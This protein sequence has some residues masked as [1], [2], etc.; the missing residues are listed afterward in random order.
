MAITDIDQRN[1]MLAAI[2]EFSEDAIISK[3]LNGY[4]TSWNKSA[5]RMFGYTAEEAIG[6]NIELI[7]PED[8]KSEEK[9]IISNLREG[10][11]IEHF[12]TIRLT[13]SGQLI[14][15]SLTVSPIKNSLGVVTGA[16]KIARDIT[17]QVLAEEL[18]S[19]H[20]TRL[21]LINAFGRKIV[22]HLDVQT[23]LQTVT[24][25]CTQLSGAVFGA[26]FYNKIDQKG[27]TYTLYTLSGA[28]KE[29]FDKFGMPRN[30][31]V[32][33]ATFLG[34]SPVRSDDITKDPR[35]GKNYPHNGMPKGHLPVVSYLAVPVVS[36]TGAVI[37]GLFFGHPKACVFK[38]EHELLVTA[39]ASQASI[40]L[41]N[42]KLYEDVNSL[43]RKKDE[44]IGFI[45]HELK[46][47][48]TTL[49][50]YLEISR[51]NLEVL[52]QVQPKLNKQVRRLEEIISDL[53]DISKIEA[54][55][56]DFSFSRIGLCALVKKSLDALN[57]ADHE[58]EFETPATEI[59]VNVD[60]QKMTQVFVNLLSNAIKYSSPGTKI[61]LTAG[62]FGSEARFT[63][64]DQG[65]GILPEDIERIFSQF[66]RVNESKDNVQGIGLGLYI[67]R[68]IV[69]GH[70]G[71]IWAE[72]EHGKG[73]TFYVSFPVERS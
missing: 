10:R 60:V 15:I 7:I 45:S 63:I 12:K 57:H 4:I 1:S 20:A 55:K 61:T 36:H 8:R 33:K 44:F 47:P 43:N 22:S 41:D 40:A 38:E 37:G 18:I 39:I 30:T 21:E 64:T 24:D 9:V 5:E 26:F 65:I 53:L 31:E 2:I 56:L 52:A 58:I 27:E 14:H 23:I 54:G 48:L 35:Y 50:G 62:Q 46:T 32:F 28:S 13:K 51:D 66:Y 59:A 72:S 70:L 42:A 49:K 73:S 16:S 34:N 6:R 71:R 29:A 17:Q 69:D 67:S 25:A 3:D 68:Q 19:Q 11:P